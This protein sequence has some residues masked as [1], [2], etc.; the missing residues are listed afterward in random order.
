MQYGKINNKAV[1]K[2]ITFT[3]LVGLL[4]LVRRN[5]LDIA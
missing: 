1:P 3:G 5:S 2:E 4:S